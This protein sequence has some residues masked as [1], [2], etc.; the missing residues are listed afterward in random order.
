MLA[1]P[2]MNGSLVNS[3]PITHCSLM[4]SNYAQ[5]FTSI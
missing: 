3:S 1:K 5:Y 2:C 4:K